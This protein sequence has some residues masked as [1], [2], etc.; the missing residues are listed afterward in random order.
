MGCIL[1]YNTLLVNDLWRRGKS[2]PCPNIVVNEGGFDSAVKSFFDIELT[3]RE[4]LISLIERYDYIYYP[5]FADIFLEFIQVSLSYNIR[6]SILE[7][8]KRISQWKAVAV[9]FHEYLDK[10]GNEFYQNYLSGTEGGGNIMH[11][12]AFLCDLMKKERT[13]II[14]Y[15]NE[16]DKLFGKT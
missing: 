7:D 15:Q 13:I 16:I 6:T 12:Y 11:P 3:I 10:Y 5:Q 8:S 2:N 9:F 14:S 1:L 4:E